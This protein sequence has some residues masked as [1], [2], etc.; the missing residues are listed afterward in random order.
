MAMAEP[1]SGITELGLNGKAFGAQLV[2]FGIVIFIVWRWVYRP[3]LRLMDARTAR[4]EQGLADAQ[5]ASAERAAAASD[6]A[7]EL[8]EAQIEAD[9]LLHEAHVAAKKEGDHQIA[10]AREE[11]AR[12]LATTRARLAHEHDEALDSLKKDL[13]QLVGLAT[14]KV[15]REALK[16]DDHRAL[17]RRAIDELPSTRQS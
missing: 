14:E 4:I 17:I 8:K 9:D 12:E 13:A 15:T 3:L 2:N 6:R 16:A 5:Q 11:A 7:R 1:V 10:K